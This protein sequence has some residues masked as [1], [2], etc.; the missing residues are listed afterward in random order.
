MCGI[1]GMFNPAGRLGDCTQR[2][3]SDAM[4][5]LRHRAPDG[6]DAIERL[7]GQCVLGHVRL[8]IIDLEEGNSRSQ[9]KIKHSGSFVTAR[10]TTT[11]NYGRHW[12]TAGTPSEPPV[13]PKY[14]FTCT[15][16]RVRPC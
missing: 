15:S 8:A 4:R 14:C 9:T 2:W 12:K 10:S 11:W 16:R 5:L 3:S 6:A 1:Y 7:D 13:T